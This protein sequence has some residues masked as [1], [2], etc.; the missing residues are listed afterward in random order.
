MPKFMVYASEVVYYA[1]EVEAKDKDEARD[2]AYSMDFGNPT[3]G[4]NFQIDEIVEEEYA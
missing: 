1:L 3:D 4:D 2:K